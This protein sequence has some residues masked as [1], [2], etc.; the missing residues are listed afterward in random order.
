MQLYTTFDPGCL[1]DRDV[2]YV[3]ESNSVELRAAQSGSVS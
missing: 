1:E 3:A 2:S